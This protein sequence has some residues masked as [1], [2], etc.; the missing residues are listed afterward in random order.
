M[1]DRAL[2]HQFGRLAA[3]IER[4][5]RVLKHHLDVPRLAADVF[6]RHL[7][8]SRVPSSTIAPESGSISR[9]MQR[10][11]VDLPEPHSPTMPSVAP[12]GS[13]SETSLTAA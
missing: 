9:T 7:R 5:E 6:A 2:R 12:R 3:R 11:S 4:G 1:D 8:A 13:D 10:A